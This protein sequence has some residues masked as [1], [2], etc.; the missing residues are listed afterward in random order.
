[1]KRRVLSLITALALCLSL[2]PVRVWAGGGDTG[3]LC[4]HHPSHTDECGY[5]PPARGRECA[6]KHDGGCYATETDCIHEHSAG[7]YSNSDYDPEVDEPDLCTHTCTQDSGCVTRTLSCPHQHDEACGYAPEEPGRPCGFACGLCAIESLIGGLPGSISADNS[8]QVYAQL[9]EI[10]ELYDR[11][12]AEEQEQVD[13]SPCLSLQEQADGISVEVLSGS[14]PNVSMTDRLTADAVYKDRPYE[15]SIDLLVDTNGYTLRGINCSAIRV[16]AGGSLYLVGNVVSEKGAGVEVQ[17]GGFLS[18]TENADISGKTYGLDVASGAEVRLSSGTYTGETAAIRAA[19]GS[20]AG[21][22]E[23]GCA[24]FVGGNP[25]LPA[26]AASAA[27]VTVGSCT[28]TYSYTKVSGSP[29]HTRTCAVCGAFNSEKC[30]FD[31]DENGHGTCR[32]QCGNSLTIAVNGDDLVYDGTSQPVNVTPAVTLGDGTVL[33]KDTD[34]SV[35]CSARVDVGTVTVTVSGITFNGTFTETYSIKQD[36]PEL[37]WDTSAKPAPIGVDYDGSPVEASDL[38]PVII[39]IESENDNLQEYLQYSYKKQSDSSY[40]DGLP[41][42]AGTYDVKVSLPELD[43]FHAAS[44]EPITLTINKIA[45][46]SAP[47]AAEQLTFNG[48]AQKLVTAGTLCGTAKRDGIEI[49]FAASENGGYSTEIP[50]GVDARDY[51]VWYRIAETGNYN[52]VTAKKVE[53]VKIQPKQITPKV[54]LSQSSYGYDGSRKEPKITVKD[55]DAVIDEEQYTVTWAN[56]SGQEAELIAA[57]TYTA[58]I[59][60]VDK[61]NYK[62]TARATVDISAA[63]QDA[64][65]ITGKPANV[66]YG[67]VI[68]TLDT[69]GGSEN[70]TVKWTLTGGSESNI[71][72]ATGVLEI[73]DVGELTV[74]AERTVDNYRTVTDTWTFTVKPKP[75]TAEV[76][77]AGKDYDGTTDIAD[78]NIRAVVKAGDLVDPADN[79]TISG[80]TGAYVDANAGA[81]KAVALDDSGVTTTADPAKYTLSC[82]GSATADITPRSVAVTVTLSDHDLQTD[83]S[84]TPSTYF[85]IY[86][87]TEKTPAAKVTA[88]DNNAVLEASDYSVSYAGNKNFGTAAVTVKSAAGGNYTF[89]DTKVTFAIR[90]AEARL[91][92]S[93]QKKDL[94]YNGTE[95]ELVTV[96]TAEGGRVEYSLDNASYGGIPKKTAAGTYTVY[97]KAVGDGNHTDSAVGSVS[98]TIKPKE[99]ISPKITVSG[100]YT[101]DGSRKEPSGADVVVKDSSTIIPASEY[102]LTYSDNVNAGTAAVHV[103]NANGGNYIVNG[104]A[105]FEI[106]KANASVAKAPVG[107]SLSY[108]GTAQEL[109]TAG[110]AASGTMV[111]SLDENGPYSPDIPTG[112]AVKPYLVWYKAQGDSNYNDSTANS[113]NASIIVNNVTAPIIQVTP[114]TAAFNGQRQEPVVTVQDGKGFAIDSSEYTVTYADGSGNSDLTK[115]GTYAVTI[116]NKS[117][118]NYIINN[119]SATFTIL[120]AGQTPLTITGKPDKV[121]YGDTLHLSTTGGSGGGAV[122]W[123]LVSGTAQNEGA[124]QFKITGA[125]SVTIKAVKAAEGGYK[126]TTDTWTFYAYQKPVAAIV[127]AKDKAYDGGTTAEFTVIIGGSDVISGDKFDGVTAAGHFIDENVGTDKTVVIEGLTIPPEVS[128][129][130]AISWPATAEASITKGEAKLATPPSPNNR[131]YDPAIKDLVAGGTTVNNVGTIE[132]SLDKDGEY[133]ATIPTA[134]E[135]GAYTVWYM[136]PGSAN[137]TGIDPES[138]VVTIEQ[139]T[140]SIEPNPVV[141]GTA[142]QKLSEVSLSG[143]SAKVGDTVVPGT[144]AWENGEDIVQIGISYKAVFT[145]NDTKNYKENTFDVTVKA[146]DGTGDNT[147]GTD[148]NAG[149]ADTPSTPVTSTPSPPNSMNA[150]SAP[151]RATV[152]N[153]T[154][155]TVVSAAQGSKLVKEAIENQSQTVVIKPEVTG[156]VSKSEVSIPAS[157]MSQIESETNADLTVSAPMADVTI[158]RAALSTLS[159]AGG[160]VSVVTEQVGQ[161]VVVTLSADGESLE[162]VPGGLTLT[163][164][165]ED[166]GPGTVAVLVREDGAR[167]TIRKSM[168]KDG[169]LSIP[170]DGSAAVEIVDN[171]K[172]FADVPSTSWEADAVAFA[173]A[174]ELFSGTSETTF[175]PDQPMTR[176][177]LATVLYNLEG[178]PDQEP[179]G[180]FSDVGSDA[181]Y[182][183]GVSWAAAN[184]ITNGTSDGQF[185]PDESVTREQF[186]VMLWRYAGSPEPSGGGLDFTDADQVSGYALEAMRWATS[187]GILNGH[188]NGQ[189]DPGGT[190]TR[191]QAAQMLK[192]FMENTW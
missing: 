116:K 62:F 33:A 28:H 192:N 82:P 175:S 39:N 43:N 87:G 123:E 53:N 55:G 131:D 121:Y 5:A 176:G 120:P 59:K 35:D 47:P 160:A 94:T 15:V 117:D 186:A 187:N 158:S 157:M 172:D 129:K 4:P 142:G 134:T 20:L 29:T 65:N 56:S 146:A 180:A 164:P 8:E 154:A 135:V 113:V 170:L 96:G 161:S 178:Q 38:P 115:A 105:T 99:I 50:T 13:L 182:A 10:Y 171:S 30:T 122:A 69:V 86:D 93:P 143:I 64:L 136:V 190:A 108:N 163:V 151:M 191:A 74:T 32:E 150:A 24:Y 25:V 179:A 162:S 144:F 71:N 149:A 11:L 22:L 95:Q 57:G 181:W 41:T 9:S 183:D 37:K 106:A 79:F 174:H 140:P 109:V 155:T 31:F 102:N 165:A 52:G 1:M 97:Y 19:D 177:M 85:Y 119:S 27:S 75:V 67:D 90:K 23:P 70:G 18:I 49:L 111:Y 12:T 132:Y 36:Q 126:E 124:G 141:I 166:A 98:V 127:T 40:T 78:G 188:G 189:L 100:T 91:T 110:S 83:N 14:A 112:T 130:Y 139:A 17:S 169:G 45:P 138:V 104:T 156:D 58:T 145:P 60:S 72:Q 107:S 88:N 46:I 128:A 101:Y 63:A 61:G 26:M 103:N 76:T 54:E 92:S 167:E 168:V 6:H 3:G 44:S 133:S 147:G 81:G 21:L 42:N 148:D 48:T 77:I 89:A 80:L 185:G 125:G 73:K 137:Y 159:R 66:R 184:G 7:C 16:V 152:Q 68:T 34:Y 173:S 51:E 2:C 114:G 84:T 118:S 153:G